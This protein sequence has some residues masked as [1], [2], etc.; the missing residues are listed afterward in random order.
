VESFRFSDLVHSE[1]RAQSEHLFRELVSAEREYFQLETRIASGMGASQSVRWTVWRVPHEEGKP[2]SALVLGEETG[3]GYSEQ[4][5]RQAERLESVGRLA[6]GVAHDFNNLLTGVL[7][8]CDLLLGGLNAGH[9]MR[10]YA[11]EVRG[12]AVQA[13]GMVQQLLSVAR[14][15]NNVAL[16][17]SLNEV[18][19]GMRSLLARLLGENIELSFQLDPNLGL[20]EMDPSR[21]Q[22]VLLNLALNARDALPNGGRIRVETRNGKLQILDSSRFVMSAAE[23]PCALFV[24]ND[25]GGGMDDDTRERVFE[26]FFT[27]K[28]AGEGT[29]LGLATVHDIVTSAGGLIHVASAKGRGTRVTLLLPLVTQNSISQGMA[30]AEIAPSGPARISPTE[31]TEGNE[32]ELPLQ[33]KETML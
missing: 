21:A 14:P 13:T 16:P 1:D 19:Q 23:L 22:Q 18:A 31:R 10:R 6:G 7:L 17:L 12:A 29:G 20:I 24:V 5:L 26:A 15:G 25:D 4:R 2:E 11:E 3:G 32:G 33:E 27:T 9:P 28:P 8:Y 30:P